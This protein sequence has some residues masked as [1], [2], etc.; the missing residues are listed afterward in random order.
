MELEC[1]ARE[2]VREVAFL[3]IQTRFP[4]TWILLNEGDN[5]EIARSVAKHIQ[6]F[7]MAKSLRPL[8]RSRNLTG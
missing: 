5:V 6:S 8:V 4:N 7:E 3:E 1:W 2:G